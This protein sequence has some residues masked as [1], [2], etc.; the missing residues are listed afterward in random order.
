MNRWTAVLLAAFG[1]KAMRAHTEDQ[2][3]SIAELRAAASVALAESD[4]RSLF[5]A[6][7]DAGTFDGT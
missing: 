4:K 1:L 7:S 2:K 3:R 6:T 5:K